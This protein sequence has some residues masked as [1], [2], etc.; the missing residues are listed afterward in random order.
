MKTPSKNCNGPFWHGGSGSWRRTRA[1]YQLVAPGGSWRRTRT[2][3]QL[4]APGGS[5]RRNRTE[6]QL[7]ARSGRSKTVDRLN[8]LRLQGRPW[9]GEGLKDLITA[10]QLR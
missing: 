2:D 5:W 4:A 9:G 6:Y 3:Y 10:L 8:R 7:A 1:D